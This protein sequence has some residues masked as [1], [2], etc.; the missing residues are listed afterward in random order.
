MDNGLMDGWAG[1]SNCSAT[2]SPPYA[3]V[4]YY[5]QGQV[6]NITTL[7]TSFAVSDHTFSMA[8]SPSF[9]GHL[10]AAAASIDGFTGNNPRTHA[11]VA[12]GPGWG[13]DSNLDA[14][15]APALGATVQQVPSCVPDPSLNPVQYP[16]GGAYRSTPVS[17][18]P[19][20]M[21]SLD[22]AGLPWRLYTS[23][24]TTAG[25]AG[26]GG[27]YSWAICPILRRSAWTQLSGSNMV[28][29]N[30]FPQR[31]EQRH[32]AELLDRASARQ[33]QPADD[34]NTTGHRWPRATTGSA[35]LLLRCERGPEWGVDRA[36]HHLRRLRLFLR[37]SRAGDQP[38]RHAA[39]D[40]GA[41]GHR[42]AICASR[43]TRIP[44]L[45]RSP[46][47]SHTRSRPWGCPRLASTTAAP[48]AFTNSFDYTQTP[49]AAGTDDAAERGQRGCC[50]TG[51]ERP[52]LTTSAAR[53]RRLDLAR[54]PGQKELMGSPLLGS[55][56]PPR[57][58][59]PKVSSMA[60]SVP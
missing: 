39:G 38:R 16:Y 1:V 24:V 21:D 56:A 4:S 35:R 13:C 41:P 25:G 2:S 40:P 37:P 43:A 46:P 6:P 30:K 57:R 54:T 60:R 3:C 18:V 12:A 47:S 28:P 49:L 58:T 34:R 11:G 23:G 27:Q 14:S 44:R 9:G 19:T 53:H 45:R 59:R 32:T 10:Y 7:A 8:D 50:H 20:I 52:N 55:F 33:R 22:A 5:S 29:V 17:Q 26:S 51:P 48:Y 42:V 36:V 15:W 31:R